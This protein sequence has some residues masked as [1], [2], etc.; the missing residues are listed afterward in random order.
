MEIAKLTKI[1]KNEPK[2]RASQIQQAIFGELVDNWNVVTGLPKKLREELQKKYP[3]DIKAKIL[4]SDDKNTIKALITLT[5]GNTIETVLMKHQGGRNTV[6]V[7]C[8]IGCPMGCRF[9]ATGQM[10][11]IR[12]LSTD[13]IIIQVLFFARYLKPTN[14]RVGSVVFMGMGEPLLNYNNVM[15]AIKIIQSKEGFGIGARHISV[16]TCGI[17]DG[18]KKLAQE[19]LDINLAISLHAPNDQIRQQLMSIA[20]TYTIKELLKIVDDYITN[21]NRKVMFEYLMIQ[22]VNDL[23]EHAYE[24]A[25]LMKN[26]LC[27]VNLIEYNPTGKFTPSS[28]NRINAF[29]NILQK[30]GITTTMRYRFGQDIKGACGQLATNKN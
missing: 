16:S 6:C 13:E 15:A 12:E 4:T 1:L 11:L 18:I 24:L 2:Y 17:L 9:C 23:D 28:H 30:N 8:H 7:S 5:D 25:K 29:K 14:E 20:K 27:V 19:N 21:K 10:G 3:L 22:G 26:R